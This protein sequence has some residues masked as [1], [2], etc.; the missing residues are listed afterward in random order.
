MEIP[1]AVY[2][3]LEAAARRAAACAYCPY[4]RF[5]VGAA[6]VTDRGEI[7]AGCNVENASFGLT[8]CAERNAVFQAVAQSH[9]RLVI[10][11]VM[12]YTPTIEPTAPCG[13]C[14]QV[15]NEFGPDAE[16]ISICD[17]PGT[18]YSRLGGLLPFAFGP[19]NLGA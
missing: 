19:H 3:S 7:F 6:L 12:V 15:I 11:A 10:R 5:P 16:V 8:I 18:I 17:G 4:S 14:R 9:A 2:S 13:A 1:E